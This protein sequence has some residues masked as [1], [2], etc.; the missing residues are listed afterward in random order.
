MPL[1]L[2]KDNA[3]LIRDTNSDSTAVDAVKCRHSLSHT[4]GCDSS[5]RSNF[6]DVLGRRQRG[7]LQKG[8]SDSSAPLKIVVS[9]SVLFGDPVF[10]GD[11]G[12]CRGDDFEVRPRRTSLTEHRHFQP[13]VLQASASKSRAHDRTCGERVRQALF[14]AVALFCLCDQ[15]R[16]R[17]NRRLPL[18]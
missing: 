7:W 2:A 15:M 16:A 14:L 10:E 17:L 1:R 11:E 18:F 9:S 5:Q 13:A 3:S 12:P 4:C 6:C 8:L